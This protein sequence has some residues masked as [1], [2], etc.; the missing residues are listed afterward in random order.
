MTRESIFI[1]QGVFFPKRTVISMKPLQFRERKKTLKKHSPKYQYIG[2]KSL[3]LAH[4]RH[5]QFKNDRVFVLRW[6]DSES[7]LIQLS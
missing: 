6:F 3:I 4:W 2:S 1:S 5:W 7:Y